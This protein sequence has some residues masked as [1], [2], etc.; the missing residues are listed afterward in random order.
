MSP[1]HFDSL[2]SALVDAAFKSLAL[3]MIAGLVAMVL[4]RRSAAARH[5][6]WFAALG[7][8]LALPVLS[9]TLPHWSILLVPRWMAALGEAAS[10]PPSAP[11]KSPADRSPSEISL[12][13]SLTTLAGNPTASAVPNP[14][15]P[16]ALSAPATPSIKS[17]SPKPVVFQLRTTAPL[18][19][20]TW[21]AMAW[22]A[23][24][25]LTLA[26]LL[27]GCW[28]ISRVTRRAA[29]CADPLETTQLGELCAQL[30]LR[31]SVDLRLS[32]QIAIPL[33]WGAWRP[34]LL[35]P[36]SFAE[37]TPE[38]QRLVLLHE[39]A[40][41]QRWDWLGQIA[42]RVAC[43]I[44]W[45]NP[46]A[47]MAARQ[48]RLEREQACDDLVLAS[49]TAPGVYADELLQIAAGMR[50]PGWL[51]LAT[52][53]MA[54]R[55]LLEVRLR[56]V[57]DRTRRRQGITRAAIFA[58]F[59]LGAAIVAPLA[60]LHA[61]AAST[62]PVIPPPPTAVIGNR[63]NQIDVDYAEQD[64]RS[65]LQGLAVFFDLNVEIDPALHGKSTL[66]LQHATW[67][68]VF[69]AV[70]IPLG[71]TYIVDGKVIR[72]VKEAATAAPTVPAAAS[73]VPMQLAVAPRFWVQDE[74]IV[75]R[76][77][78]GIPATNPSDSAAADE[79]RPGPSSIQLNHTP[80]DLVA[81]LLRAWSGRAVAVPTN[82]PKVSVIYFVNHPLGWDEAVAGLT[83]ALKTSGIGIVTLADH[84]MQLV[85][86]SSQPPAG[87]GVQTSPA[88]PPK[89]ASPDANPAVTH[90][91]T[92]FGIPASKPLDDA[93]NVYVAIGDTVTISQSLTGSRGLVKSGPGT[94][95][96]TGNN[97][98]TGRVVVAD[99]TLIFDNAMARGGSR[100]TADT[101]NVSGDRTTA[102]T[103]RNP[104]S[105]TAPTPPRQ[106][107][108]T[109]LQR[110][111]K[112]DVD[113]L[114]QD[115]RTILQ[116]IAELFG[117]D[118]IYP[119]NLPGKSTLKLHDVTSRQIL[120]AALAPIG[121]GFVEDGYFI[122]I[123]K[124]AAAAPAASS[125][126]PV[127]NPANSPGNV[128]V[129]AGDTRTISQ[130]LTGSGTL[131]KSGPGT[132]VLTGDNARTGGTVIDSGTLVLGTGGVIVSGPGTVFLSGKNTY[133]GGTVVNSG[134]LMLAGNGT[135]GATTNTLTVNGGTVDLEANQTVSAVTLNGGVITG[136]GT[137]TTGGSFELRSGG[138][139]PS[140]PQPVAAPKNGQND[141]DFQDKDNRAILQQVAAIFALNLIIPDNLPGKSTL[142]LHDVTW[143]QILKAILDP[144]GY[145]FV[146]DGNIIK[147]VQQNTGRQSTEQVLHGKPD[148]VG[149]D[150]PFP[151]FEFNQ[152]T[153]AY[154][155]SGFELRSGG[156][157]P[158]LAQPLAAPKNDRTDIDFQNKDN[159]A[160]LQ[161]VAAIFA[162]NLI[163]PD[164][165][166]GK[167]TLKLHDVTWQQI[168]KA[169]LDPIGY[170]FVEDGNIIKI[171]NQDP[172]SHVVSP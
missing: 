159:R 29:R 23:G 165:L 120:T 37:W 24:T 27:A 41:V 13:P 87:A 113:I 106:T 114:D 50:G 136:P 131:V 151:R 8:A 105:A 63:E 103:H 115:N 77:P 157:P 79:G 76:T 20:S 11:I 111:H 150:F 101:V 102:S 94:L 110:N 170:T 45:F 88:T 28:Q 143:Q 4:K 160:V 126:V 73:G 155:V 61:S 98:F 166:P 100:L 142:K 1:L 118:L 6:V 47:W 31:R 43:A 82:L 3:F 42:G 53:P 59:L 12:P 124:Q 134:T 5:L 39:L 128:F 75:G 19:L 34:V 130:P 40:H 153:G 97:S 17:P 70:L 44:Y 69:K 144:I 60:M 48:M 107:R 21:L 57:L 14:R 148:A 52:V 35:L 137:L 81:D 129:A 64:T 149:G 26:P 141:F 51:T 18:N 135:L 65:I 169:V 2:P 123:V 95:V 36:A 168:L 132:L 54:H 93:D 163:I 145:T 119:D 147:I 127:A 15:N 90:T 83:A 72:V 122:K 78:P 84:S 156:S 112:G 74:T 46:L 92:A 133:T 7:G 33:T 152:Q 49:G 16:T 158:S 116:Q 139:P 138:S 25:M 89:S 22:L 109:G 85:E 86:L 99:G 172:I 38:R 121:Y 167:S 117:L 71:Y 171:V 140:L 62:D 56:A 67:E 30:R 162:L 104:F 91:A 161:N 68:Q 146:E 55:S 164:K 125:V 108:P 32:S 9:V 10:T 96:L 80:L 154:V 58:M 66:K